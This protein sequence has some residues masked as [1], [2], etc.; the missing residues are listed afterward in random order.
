MN[1]NR[2]NI[3]RRRAALQ[4]T[5][6][7][8]ALVTTGSGKVV[9]AQAD[10]PVKVIMPGSAGSGGSNT[11]RAAAQAFS[12]ALGI[13][14][15]VEDVPGAGG[16][17]GTQAVVRAAPDGY[18]LSMVSNNH[19]IYPSVYKSVPFDP[20]ADVT[21]ISV[22]G[23]TPIVMLVNPTKMPTKSSQEMVAL[24]KA[25]PGKFNYG[26]AGNGT[27]LHLAGAM[28]LEEAG[29]LKATHV[30]YK[31]TGPMLTDLLGGQLDFATSTLPAARQHIQNGTLRAIGVAANVR[32]AAAMEIPTFVEQGI[33]GYIIEVWYAVIGPAK[34][35]PTNIS[36]IHGALVTAFAATDVKEVMAKQGNMINISTPEYASKYFLTETMKYA[37]LVKLAGVEV[38]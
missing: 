1:S 24:I 18:T 33:P 17:V 26:S 30:P 7:V 29:S 12:K 14:V 9:L 15:V 16:I 34:M 20:I 28:F 19:V 11:M 2:N 36:R 10:R 13:P 22:I 8:L 37:K 3:S 23:T 25:N 6:G 21:P 27:I 35:S 31:G 4:L 38:Q 32:Q 5:N